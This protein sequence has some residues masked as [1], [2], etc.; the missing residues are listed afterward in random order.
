MVIE[1]ILILIIVGLIAALVIFF[2]LQGQKKGLEIGEKCNV[3]IDC[4]GWSL[5]GPGTACCGGKCATKVRDHAGNYYCSEEAVVAPKLNQ[6]CTFGGPACANSGASI[7]LGTRTNCCQGTCKTMLKGFD[8]TYWCP[9]ECKKTN[10][11]QPGTCLDPDAPAC[12]TAARVIPYTETSWG[13]SNIQLCKIGTSATTLTSSN[14]PLP[15]ST[16]S[17]TCDANNQTTTCNAGRSE[18]PSSQTGELLPD[19]VYRIK[20][21][22]SG[23]NLSVP[24]ATGDYPVMVSS[25]ADQWR[26]TKVSGPKSNPYDVPIKLVHVQTGKYMD[27]HENTAAGFAV[28]LRDNQN[29]DSQTWQLVTGP[30]SGIWF[31]RQSNTGRGL[32]TDS[33]GKAVTKLQSGMSSQHWVMEKV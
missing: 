24:N 22:S 13:T 4:N 27:A 29:N 11:S 18:P 25:S 33:S 12:G 31:V 10:T 8:G 16:L 3:G 17:W 7:P 5:T 6:P 15:G 23:L 28:V 21:G 1:L 30:S 32:D 14:F 2:W 19:G 20:Q 9:F 26:V